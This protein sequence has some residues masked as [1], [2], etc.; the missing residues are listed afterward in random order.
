M[1]TGGYLEAEVELIE[2][3]QA[4]MAKD[5]PRLPYNSLWQGSIGDYPQDVG[6]LLVDGVGNV[7]D[8][9]VKERD[10]VGVYAHLLVCCGASQGQ[11]FRK[12]G[13]CGQQVVSCRAGKV[14]PA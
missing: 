10:W 9:L 14:A 7:N 6:Q 8:G 2:G 12:R 11:A 3:A 1:S 13:C 4:G 5:Y